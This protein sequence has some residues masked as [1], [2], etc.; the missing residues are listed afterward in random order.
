MKSFFTLD[1]PPP[2]NPPAGVPAP[3]LW[4]VQ[5]RRWHQ[6]TPAPCDRGAKN[7]VCAHCKQAW[8]CHSWA[9]WDGQIAE[10]FRHVRT[11]VHPTR[12]PRTV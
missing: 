1:N 4:R 10:A 6:H 7:P 3:S 9:C 11:S 5:R 2:E 12:R 8:P